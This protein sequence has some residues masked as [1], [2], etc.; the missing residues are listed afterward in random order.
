VR[1]A[2][3]QR[4]RG[5]GRGEVLLAA[6][7]VAAIVVSGP[8]LDALGQAYW[9][10]AL[11]R[12][13]LLGVL[14]ITTDL[15][16]GTT[17]IFTLGQAVFFGIGAYATG[18]ISTKDEVDSLLELVA[19]AAGAGAAAGAIL[20]SFLFLGRRRVGALYVGLVTLALTY[21]LERAA[22]T[23]DTLGAA[24]GIPGLPL[25][26]LFGSELDTGVPL[27]L[28]A[29]A[30]LAV[31]L[32]VAVF[33]R[34]SQLGLAMRAVRD[35]DERAEFLG[36]RRSRIQVLVFSLCAALAAA[37]GSVYGLNEGFVSPT[38]LGVALSTQALVYVIL[39]GRGTLFGP[40]LGVLVLEVGGQRVQESLPTEWPI[41]IGSVLLLV[42][43][44][45]PG[46]LSDLGARL[47]QLV[48]GTARTTRSEASR[49]GP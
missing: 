47:R 15:A 20:G 2:A 30:L 42:I 33:L 36:Y 17:G 40:L 19:I 12:A 32:A 35:D 44:V 3:G 28:V 10:T 48:V 38:F 46:G 24:N 5:R 11:T 29:A 8:L 49:A 1:L 34:S 45:L 13:A 21:V 7:L 41:V 22:N 43:V 27:F 18:L 14:A 4:W 25:P 31:T 26:T 9:V 16:W 6:A 37:A 23:W 39:G